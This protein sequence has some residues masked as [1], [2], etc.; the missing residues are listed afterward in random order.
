MT[1]TDPVSQEQSFNQFKAAE[2]IKTLYGIHGAKSAWD[3]RTAH[4]QKEL[5][6]KDAEIDALHKHL[7]ACEQTEKELEALALSFETECNG[8]MKRIR[9]LEGMI[10]HGLGWEDMKDDH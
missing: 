2:G 4:Y 7:E 10:E 3:N 8:H 9:K 6:E 1:N 5:A